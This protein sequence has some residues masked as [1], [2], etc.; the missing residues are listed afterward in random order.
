M[1]E[2]EKV[3]GRGLIAE[4]KC[5]DDN[6]LFGMVRNI[7]RERPERE[8][9]HSPENKNTIPLKPQVNNRYHFVLEIVNDKMSMHALSSLLQFFITNS[10]FFVN[11]KFYGW[12]SG[13]FHHPRSQLH[14]NFQ[15]SFLW[16]D[17]L[18]EQFCC[19]IGIP[20]FI[21]KQNEIMSKCINQHTY[22]F[23]QEQWT[24]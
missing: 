14:V 18:M 12:V 16:S 15:I 7:G 22:Y 11:N 21:I 17:Y 10:K 13:V 1:D 19:N 5:L 2:P 23:L 3:P 20:T 24:S 4:M 8:G 6:T 9:I